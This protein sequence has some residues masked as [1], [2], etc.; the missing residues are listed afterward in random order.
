M[1]TSVK[2]LSLVALVLF[3]VALAVWGLMADLARP[4]WG[5]SSSC[6]VQYQVQNDWGTGATVNVVIYNYSGSPV[7]GWTLTWTFP[8]NQQITN[9]WSAVHTQNGQNVAATNVDYNAT[10]PANGGSVNFGFNLSYSGT[11]GTPSSF[12]LNG[13]AC[14][15]AGV[16]PTPTATPTRTPTPTATQTPTGS[17]TPPVTPTP[18]ISNTIGVS[19][20]AQPAPGCREYTVTLRVSGYPPPKPVDVILVIDRSGSMNEPIPGDPNRPIYY[21]KQAALSFAQQ[22]LANPN[23][24]VAI[25]SYSDSAT[26]NQGLTNN[27]TAVQNAIN[28]LSAS[29]YTNIQQGFYV[30]RTHMQ[31]QGRP[32]ATTARAIVL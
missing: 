9:I 30:A 17:P 18:A 26:L 24:R 13:Q 5:Q 12:V 11:N 27:L 1:R 14:T 29:G 3:G 23:N 31:S 28:G 20:I 32:I 22:V 2:Q 4:A 7:N 19:K 6:G 8:G 15:L 16:T 21:A 25:A 10:I